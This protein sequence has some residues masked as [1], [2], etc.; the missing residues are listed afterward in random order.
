MME[1]VLHCQI[2]TIIIN[3]M[4]HHILLSIMIHFILMNIRTGILTTEAL[5]MDTKY[6][7]KAIQ[8]VG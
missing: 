2:W 6:F 5:I 8:M 3:I 1:L 7:G 4:G